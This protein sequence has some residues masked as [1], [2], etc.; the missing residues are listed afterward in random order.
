MTPPPSSLFVISLATSSIFL[1]PFNHCW[2]FHSKRGSCV[3]CWWWRQMQAVL[4]CFHPGGGQSSRHDLTG[5]LPVEV[6][7]G[8]AGGQGGG[9]LWCLRQPGVEWI[10]E[11][12][13]SIMLLRLRFERP[14][15][16]VCP[17]K[18]LLKSNILTITLQGGLFQWSRRITGS[19]MTS[20]QNTNQHWLKQWS[21]WHF[22]R[23]T[24]APA[25]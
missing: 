16:C 17:S 9:Y 10:H 8:D 5:R 20:N 24:E 18:Q 11:N 21:D 15:G 23:D 25:V 2:T 4:L 12:V 22:Q 19:V 3:H 6:I 7:V 1:L 13:Q 14:R